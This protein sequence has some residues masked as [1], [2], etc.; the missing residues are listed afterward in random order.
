MQK[1]DIH[2][3]KIVCVAQNQY[4]NSKRH[5]PLYIIGMFQWGKELYG[6]SKS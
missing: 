3:L 1:Y 6:R 4:G 2:N 5:S